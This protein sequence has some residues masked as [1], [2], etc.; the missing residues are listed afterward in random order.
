MRR[1]DH[2]MAV[3]RDQFAPFPVFL[4]FLVDVVSGFESSYEAQAVEGIANLLLGPGEIEFNCSV[5][6]RPALIGEGDQG[7]GYKAPLQAR[8]SCRPGH[9]PF[10]VWSRVAWD[11]SKTR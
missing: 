10:H 7:T 11:H 3:E 9:T 6:T 8:S 1:P 2:R 4:P 5:W